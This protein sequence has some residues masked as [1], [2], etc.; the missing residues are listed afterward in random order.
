[1]FPHATLPFLPV[2]EPYVMVDLSLTSGVAPSAH[3]AVDPLSV[4]QI[5][6]HF[7]EIQQLLSSLKQDPPPDPKTLTPRLAFHLQ[8]VLT[9]MRTLPLIITDDTGR[10][11]PMFATEG[12]AL[13][14]HHAFD[15]IQ[16]QLLARTA[17]APDALESWEL[18]DLLAL[19]H[20]VLDAFQKSVE[21]TTRF[22]RQALIAQPALY[23]QMLT[24]LASPQ[25][26]DLRAQLQASWDTP[27]A[28]S[29]TLTSNPRS[30]SKPN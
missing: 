18:K 9:L 27:D 22:I 29:L 26:A 10:L 8:S 24:L 17:P 19:F 16:L 2:E 14:P 6:S 3:A 12:Q 13:N 7:Q 11:C 25:D 1:M 30:S 28:S 4:E 21:I 20:S 23:H 15:R 5:Q